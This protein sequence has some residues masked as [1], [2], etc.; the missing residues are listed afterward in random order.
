MKIGINIFDTDRAIHPVEL[1]QAI[2]ARGFDA[3]YLPEH[4]HIPASRKTRW[5]GSRPGHEDPLPDYYSRICDPYVAL[6]MIAAVTERLEL[7]T[8][9]TLVPQHDPIRLAKQV[10]TLDHWSGGRVRLGIGYGWNEEQTAAHGADFRTRRGL[11]EDCVGIMR[12]LW[13]EDEASFAGKHTSLEPSWSWP[14]PAQP[15]GPPILLGG[16]TGPQLFDAITR[17]ADGWMPIT[18]R[19]TVADRAAPLKEKFAAA[20]RDPDSLKIV[21]CGA[22]TD[23][24]GLAALAEEGVDTA[25]M[26]IWS[27][28]RDE[29]LRKLDEF[30]TIRDAARGK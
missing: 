12:A 5:P 4:S 19:S 8:S 21:I 22:T 11:T 16:G 26:T 2:E 28:D 24:D 10:A 14:K 29:I 25:A 30:A 6:S 13:T 20:G 27:E 9:V 17:Y 18:G 15:G 1:G 23:P 3:L 7:G